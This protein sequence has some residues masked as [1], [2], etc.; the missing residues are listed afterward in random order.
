MRKIGEENSLEVTFVIQPCISNSWIKFDACSTPCIHQVD[1]SDALCEQER[2]VFTVQ[3]R[4]H[5]SPFGFSAFPSIFF[6]SGLENEE[7]VSKFKVVRS[8][9]DFLWLHSVIE[10]NPAYAGLI[11]PPRCLY[12]HPHQGRQLMVSFQATQTRFPS[13]PGET[14]QD[15]GKRSQGRQRAVCQSNNPKEII[16]V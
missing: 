15:G 12:L 3:A 16:A 10:E 5:H 2:V 9:E 14:D 6:G 1:I 8:H 7:L 4:Q 11:I 13:H